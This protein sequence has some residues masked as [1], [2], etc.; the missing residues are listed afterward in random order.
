M[1]WGTL[2]MHYYEGREFWDGAGAGERE[3]WRSRQ[4]RWIR[5]PETVA[6]YTAASEHTGHGCPV[7]TPLDVP[8]IRALYR[9]PASACSIAAA[10]TPVI[11][12]KLP[13]TNV[14]KAY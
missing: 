14:F 6:A 13:I 10:V 3:S 4:N 11:G 2:K 9:V 5:H 8:W 1:Y 7:D 12:V